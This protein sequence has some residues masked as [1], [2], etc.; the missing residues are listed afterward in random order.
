MDIV[1]GAGSVIGAASGI[2]N[3][4]SSLAARLGGT[5]TSYFSQLRPASFRQVPFISLGSDNAF[6]RRKQVH[7]YPQRDVP[8][9]EDLGRGIRQFRMFGFVVGDNVIAQRD[10]LIAAC[11]TAGDG[12]LVHPSLGRRTVSLVE[13]HSIERWERG[14]YFEFQFVFIEGGPR[15][16][17]TSA[18]ATTSEVISASSILDL[19][20]AAAFA[21]RALDALAQGAA[22]VGQAVST[23]LGWY[24]SAISVVADARNLFN[25]LTNLPGDFGR[26]LGSSKTPSFSQFAGA[27]STPATVTQASLVASATNNRAEV[28]SA[29]SALGAA[30]KGLD[31]S[32]IGTFTSAAQA[33]SAAVLAAT[34][35]P[36]DSVRILSVL[37]SFV[38][39]DETTDSIIGSSMST[40]QSACGDLFRR[41]AIASVARASASYLPSSSDDAVSMRDRVTDL[42]DSEIEIAGDQGEDDAYEALRS[43][44]AAVISD[45][46]QRGGA[47]SSIKTFQ[48]PGGLPVLALANRLYRD[49]SRAD[50]LLSQ[51][52]PVHP[53]F[54]P[55]SF[56]ALTS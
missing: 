29:A 41:S 13:F 47:L 10:L 44:R 50:E 5:S 42:I 22:V 48:F 37:A 26:F 30:A 15:I 8:W 14:R 51:I 39:D 56:K 11:E 34:T 49:A 33:V 21:S 54:C 18:K 27:S 31:A 17:P 46:N 25:L 19:S 40:M 3:L 1:G 43:L 32:S 23:A 55:A 35:D 38:P 9:V 4:A 28:T 24:N 6:G 20:A 45:L 16:Y 2:A 53:A 12:D 36:A 7:V 52:N